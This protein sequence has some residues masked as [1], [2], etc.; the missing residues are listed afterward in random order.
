MWRIRALT[1]SRPC[2]AAPVS[3]MRC[4]GAVLVPISAVT[5]VT[6]FPLRCSLDFAWQS[7]KLAIISSR[8]CRN[9]AVDSMRPL[10]FRVLLLVLVLDPTEAYISGLRALFLPQ[11]ALAREEVVALDLELNWQCTA[12]TCTHTTFLRRFQPIVWLRNTVQP[13]P[14]TGLEL[15]GAS[16]GSETLVV[17]SKSGRKATIKTKKHRPSWHDN[18]FSAMEAGL[19]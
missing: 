14:K 8:F 13:E 19:F 16:V 15:L 3:K 9:P 17:N 10:F 4:E 11:R 7:Q 5:T 1:C 6:A 2:S 12:H 18:G